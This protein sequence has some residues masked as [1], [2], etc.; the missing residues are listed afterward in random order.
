M[1]QSGRCSRATAATHVP[2]SS[3]SAVRDDLILALDQGTTSSR[4]LLTNSAG[5][6][7]ALAQQE[8]PATYPQSGWVEQDPEDIF[9]GQLAAARATLE[10]AGVQASDVSA[11]GIT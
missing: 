3:T 11:V 2:V 9:G 6:V 8:L 7:L 5:E 1:N 4:A 10:Q